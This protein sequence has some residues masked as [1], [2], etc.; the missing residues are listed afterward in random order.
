MDPEVIGAIVAGI[1]AVSGSIAAGFKLLF[2]RIDKM[3]AEF[4]PNGGGSM[5]DQINRLEGRV[6]DLFSI[7]SDRK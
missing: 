1:T 7:L 6:D 4:K 2:N 5:K 3:L